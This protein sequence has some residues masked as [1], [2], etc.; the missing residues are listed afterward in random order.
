MNLLAKDDVDKNSNE[1]NAYGNLD[2][3]KEADSSS[4]PEATTTNEVALQDIASLSILEEDEE[5]SENGESRSSKLVSIDLRSKKQKD[6]TN[7]G[8]TTLRP[9]QKQ[10]KRRNTLIQLLNTAFKRPSKV[11]DDPSDHSV[12]NRTLS[13][14]ISKLKITFPLPNKDPLLPFRR[15]SDLATAFEVEE[16]NI[17]DSFQNVAFQALEYK[18]RNSP[19]AEIR[20][21][22][23]MIKSSYSQFDTKVTHDSNTNPNE[24]SDFITAEPMRVVGCAIP[25]LGAHVLIGLADSDGK[26][27]GDMCISLTEIMTMNDNESHKCFKENIPVSLGGELRGRASANFSIAL[28]TMVSLSEV[29]QRASNR[30]ILAYPDSLLKDVGISSLDVPKAGPP[31]RS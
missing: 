12:S 22:K 13:T 31:R 28:L 26:L 17:L 8:A 25:E 4:V 30:D 29:R 3:G 1:N 11:N 24:Q 19:K 18:Y 6:E 15:I 5:A 16:K 2:T 14:D 27:H 9:P 7:D 20:T 10:F 21:D 23:S